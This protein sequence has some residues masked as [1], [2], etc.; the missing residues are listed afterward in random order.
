MK[1]TIM[2]LFL[3]GMAWIICLTSSL[4]TSSQQTDF[5]VEGTIN[6]SKINFEQAP[7]WVLPK[8]FAVEQKSEQITIEQDLLDDQLQVHLFTEKL[9]FNGKEITRV[10]YTGTKKTSAPK[11]AN[12]RKTFVFSSH[13]ESATG[14]HREKRPNPGR[15]KIGEIPKS[16]TAG[17]N[18]LTIEISDQGVLR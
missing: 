2:K 17:P 3:A 11:W 15:C 10:S 4:N 16:S 5:S 7:E 12:D 14:S 9:G 1:T 6:K 8:Q 13:S 18:R